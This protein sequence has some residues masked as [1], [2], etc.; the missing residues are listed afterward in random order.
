MESLSEAYFL[1]SDPLKRRFRSANN[2]PESPVMV[3]DNIN[4]VNWSLWKSKPTASMRCLDCLDAF[5][6]SPKGDLI[7]LPIK[8]STVRRITQQILKN[9]I[10]SNVFKP[11]KLFLT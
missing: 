4:A 11:G 2:A 8:K 6:A 7:S 10:G 5:N 9:C 1:A 3:P